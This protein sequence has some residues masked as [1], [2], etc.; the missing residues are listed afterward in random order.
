MLK[1]INLVIKTE[2]RYYNVLKHMKCSTKTIDKLAI[3]EY[4]NDEVMIMKLIYSV[5]EDER[6]R[7]EYMIKRYEKE[8]SLLPKGKIT[9]KITKANTYYYLKYRDG[10]KVCAKYIGINEEDIA[11]VAEQLERRKIVERLIKELKIE[12][13]KIRKMEAIV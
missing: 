5:L 4:N 7:N 12:Q 3:V 1:K 2:S 6:K 10:Q 11:I 13:A 9:P 8:L